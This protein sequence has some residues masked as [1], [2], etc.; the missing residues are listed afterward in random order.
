MTVFEFVFGLFSV[1]MSLGIAHLLGG[2]AELTRNRKRVEFSVVHALWM[3]SA[4]A[5]TVGNWA[6]LWFLRD[7]AAWPSWSVLLIITVAATC[8]FICRF[9]TPETDA[10]G[11]IDLGDFHAQERVSYFAA[12][13][14]LTILALIVNLSFHVVTSYVAAARDSVLSVIALVLVLI[15]LF[16]QARWAQLTGAIGTA[17]ISAFFLVSS[18]NIVTG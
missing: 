15:S 6:G 8:Y 10:E 13:I 12:F 2:A 3:W 5:V 17:L 9:V 16:V 1:L 14:A 11:V 4:F 18:S 7:M